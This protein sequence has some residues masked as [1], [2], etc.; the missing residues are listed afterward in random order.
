MADC[1]II[2]RSSGKP[3]EAGPEG[4]GIHEPNGLRCCSIRAL[5]V[6]Q[7]YQGGTSMFVEPK[8][9]STGSKSVTG[10]WSPRNGLE[11]HCNVRVQGSELEIVRPMCG[12]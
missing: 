2:P 3:K 4:I 12:I 7:I 8:N 5:G 1:R 6:E 9:R 10:R 11:Y